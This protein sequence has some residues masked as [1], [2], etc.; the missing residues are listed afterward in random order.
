M[1]PVR[2][3][4]EM[5]PVALIIEQVDEIQEEPQYLHEPPLPFSAPGAGVELAHPEASTR[6]LLLVHSYKSFHS[7][8]CLPSSLQRGGLLYLQFFLFSQR[9]AERC[10]PL[11]SPSSWVGR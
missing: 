1:S 11:P 3:G 10:L 5:E 8:P 6:L 2:L 9:E 7:G 4:N